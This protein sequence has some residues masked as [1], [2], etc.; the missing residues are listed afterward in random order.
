MER[1]YTVVLGE[2]VRAI[3][4]PLEVMGSDILF[5]GRKV[6]G[7]A[8]RRTRGWLLHHGTLL[9][10]EFDLPLMETLLLEPVRQPAHRRGRSHGEFVGKLPLTRAQLMS[11]ITWLAKD[12]EQS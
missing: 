7:S 8:Q 4:L 2:V 11:R 6:S 10:D 12:S 1:S 3:G 9:F 5:D